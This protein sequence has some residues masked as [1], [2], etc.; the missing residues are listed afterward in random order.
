MKRW[1]TRGEGEGD[2]LDFGL[3]RWGG[4]FVAA[5]VSLFCSFSAELR[6]CLACL[7]IRD[8]FFKLVGQLTIIKCAKNLLHSSIDIL[9]KFERV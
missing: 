3:L 9:T 8:L 7:Q 4:F 2:D 6:A 1:E 5:R